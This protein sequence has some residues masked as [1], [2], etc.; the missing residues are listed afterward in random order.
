[1]SESFVQELFFVFY[2]TGQFEAEIDVPMSD[3]NV[4]IITYLQ[5][6]D[7]VPLES[8]HDIPTPLDMHVTH[9]MWKSSLINQMIMYTLLRMLNSGLSTVSCKNIKGN[10]D[11]RHGNFHMRDWSTAFYV[12]FTVTNDA[13][14]ARKL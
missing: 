9:K 1:M 3:I 8:K 4:A 5:K 2:W 6:N 13:I 7:W 14:V 12:W 11:A 10:A